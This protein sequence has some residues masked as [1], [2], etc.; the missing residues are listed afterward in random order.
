LNAFS[1]CKIL[2]SVSGFVG[3]FSVTN[4]TSVIWITTSATSTL[5]ILMPV[6]NALQM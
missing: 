1:K 4:P 5:L 3:V 6:I 2:L